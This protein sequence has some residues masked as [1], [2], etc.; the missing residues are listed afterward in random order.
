MNS[1]RR[2]TGAARFAAFMVLMAVPGVALGQARLAISG[3]TSTVVGAPVDLTIEAYDG[4]G[5]IDA[6]YTGDKVLT[7]S[8]A[9]ASPNP[10]TN[11]TVSDKNGF[12]IPFGAIHDDQFRERRGDS[13]RK[14]ERSHDSVPGQEGHDWCHRRNPEHGDVGDKLVITATPSPWASSRLS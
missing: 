13:V 6:T 10:P 14:R 11:P 3:P 7:F 5:N 8:G 12:G 1:A 2:I 4:S 9:T